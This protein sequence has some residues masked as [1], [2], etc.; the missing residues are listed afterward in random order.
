MKEKKKLG[1]GFEDDEGYDPE[2]HCVCAKEICAKCWCRMKRRA[3]AVIK[4]I[5]DTGGVHSGRRRSH[6][7][8]LLAWS[9][10]GVG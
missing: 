4:H 3:F 6:F 5:C 7:V 9:P 2:F 10:R 1:K 8:R